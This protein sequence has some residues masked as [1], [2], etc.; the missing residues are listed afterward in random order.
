MSRWKFAKSSGHFLIMRM[1]EGSRKQLN[2]RSLAITLMKTFGPTCQLRTTVKST[3]LAFLPNPIA[4]I[5]EGRCNR[6]R[7]HWALSN[8]VPR[9]L[10][11]MVLIT[12]WT[13]AG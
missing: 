1:M 5:L 7:K 3:Y 4:C 9:M 11:I 6:G 8:F 13:L 12:D 10:W 2:W